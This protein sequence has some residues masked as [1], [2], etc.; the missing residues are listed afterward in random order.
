M[1]RNTSVKLKTVDNVIPVDFRPRKGFSAS[2]GLS[3]GFIQLYR[4]TVFHIDSARDMA[5]CGQ[6]DLARDWLRYFRNAGI[7]QILSDAG[8]SREAFDE[9]KASLRLLESEC[10]P[11]DV[12]N[13]T[14]D[15]SEIRQRLTNIENL[16]QG[17][18]A[19]ALPCES[20]SAADLSP[21]FFNQ[22]S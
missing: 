6:K 1:K 9:L 18:A 22:A 19:V 20:V 7:L 16:L 10:H 11:L 15:L 2:F 8:L 17:K 3:P 13:F 12:P 5:K 14:T 4:F 21:A